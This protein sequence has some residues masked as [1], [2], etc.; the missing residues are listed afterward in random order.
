MTSAQT[1]SLAVLR[2]EVAACSRLLVDL[3]ILD[4]SGHVSAGR[5]HLDKL[6]KWLVLG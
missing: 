6:W 1:A 2:R 4:I 3:D 5:K